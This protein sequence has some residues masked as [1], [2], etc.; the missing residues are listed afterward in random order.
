MEERT[1]IFGFLEGFLV[2]PHRE[3]FFFGVP[4]SFAGS[5]PPQQF[6]LQLGSFFSPG[7]ERKERKGFTRGV[8]KRDCESDEE[9]R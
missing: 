7:E 9:K 6:L 1:L 4:P 3:G 5:F 2:L 8:F